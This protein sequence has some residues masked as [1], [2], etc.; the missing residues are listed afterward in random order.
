MVDSGSV[1]GSNRTKGD[2]AGHLD[3]LLNVAVR[4]QQRSAASVCRL[5]RENSA[6][7]Q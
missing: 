5:A 1:S 4:M 7:G 2:A 6:P 3:V